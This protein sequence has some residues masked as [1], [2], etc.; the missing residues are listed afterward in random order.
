MDKNI[1][2]NSTLNIPSEEK[3]KE[4]GLISKVD[5]QDKIRE[6]VTFSDGSIYEGSYMAGKKH[7]MG[8][9]SWNDGSKYS[10][11]W[12]ENKIKGFGTY[13]WLDGR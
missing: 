2:N 5:I 11:E 9:Y 6:I 10:G 4:K 7:G 3:T 13:S 1:S 8:L 12:F